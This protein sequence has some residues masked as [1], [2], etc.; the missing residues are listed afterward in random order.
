MLKVNN[1]P[2][3]MSSQFSA[4]GPG[5]TSAMMIDGWSRLNEANLI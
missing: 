4:I 3:I 1:Y 5:T 2:R